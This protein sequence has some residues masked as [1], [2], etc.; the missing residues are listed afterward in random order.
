MVGDSREMVCVKVMVG[1]PQRK[2]MLCA[3]SWKV[4]DFEEENELGMGEFKI[5]PLD[6]VQRRQ[7][8]LEST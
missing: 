8:M 1:Q 4:A 2:F 3:R 7:F 6:L 5:S